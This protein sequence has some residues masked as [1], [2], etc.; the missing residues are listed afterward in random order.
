MAGLTK[1]TAK[2]CGLEKKVHP[3]VLRHCFATH[4]LDDGTDLRTIQL[5]LGHSSLEQT[6]RYLHVS[7]RHLSAAV[8]PLDALFPNKTTNPNE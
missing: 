7:K 2:R 1:V 8:S 4:L 5:L 3:H 6:A